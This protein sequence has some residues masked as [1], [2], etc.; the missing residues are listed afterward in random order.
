M[1][2]MVSML[3]SEERQVVKPVDTYPATTGRSF[4]RYIRS[5][6]RTHSPM[7]DFVDDAKSDLDIP[8]AKTWPELEAY[9]IGEGACREAIQAGR[10]WWQR[11]RRYN[12]RLS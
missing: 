2:P 9:L 4:L 12:R 1:I 8:D 11:Y 10:K 6:R 5:R 3:T 7:G